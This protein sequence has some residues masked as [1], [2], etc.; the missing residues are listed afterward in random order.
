MQHMVMLDDAKIII[1]R[2]GY[3]AQVSKDDARLE[4]WRE[5]LAC[6]VKVGA[7]LIDWTPGYGL[8]SRHALARILYG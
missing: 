1:R 7:T 3:T 2:A 6:G 4:V 5:G 8:V